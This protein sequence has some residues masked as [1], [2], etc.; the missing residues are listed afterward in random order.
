MERNV[1]RRHARL[2]RNNGAVYIEDLDS[3]NG[4]RI[5]GERISGRY[6]VKEGDLVEIGDYHLALQRQEL[7]DAADDEAAKPEGWP[8]V[9][10]VPDFRLPDEI[11]AE[12]PQPDPQVSTRD[13]IVDQPAPPDLPPAI[14]QTLSGDGHGNNAGGHKEQVKH[15]P[16]LPPFPTPQSPPPSRVPFF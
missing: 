6:E 13:T 16:Q 14:A 9:G 3:Y 11:L 10:T 2:L 5:N 4:I 15:A 1:S 8:A 7:E 12:G